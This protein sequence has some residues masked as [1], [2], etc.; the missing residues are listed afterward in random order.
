[1]LH[2]FEIVSALLIIYFR[3]P[4]IHRVINHVE[5]AGHE[6]AL[7]TRLSNRCVVFDSRLSME[8]P[9]TTN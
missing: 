3:L 4:S 2:F 9:A 1:M 8:E 7:S 5:N 6:I